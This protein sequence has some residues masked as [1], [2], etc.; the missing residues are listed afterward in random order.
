MPTL[1][2][3]LRMTKSK[4]SGN[5]STPKIRICITLFNNL[6]TSRKI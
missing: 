6:L 3:Y 2:K 1:C 4:S 5:N